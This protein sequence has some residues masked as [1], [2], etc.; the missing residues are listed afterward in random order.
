MINVFNKIIIYLCLLKNTQNKKN[1][2][3]IVY[4]TKR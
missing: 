3:S 4:F 1:V 2:I